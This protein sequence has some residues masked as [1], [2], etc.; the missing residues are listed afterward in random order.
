[1]CLALK[2]LGSSWKLSRS[3]SSASVGVQSINGWSY[4]HS[5]LQDYIS[6]IILV[7]SSAGNKWVCDPEHQVACSWTCVWAF[8]SPLDT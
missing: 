1:M 7:F 3:G 6:D 2:L 4:I 8:G 5:Y